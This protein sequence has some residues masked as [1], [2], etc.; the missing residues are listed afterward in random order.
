MVDCSKFAKRRDSSLF[1]GA[2]VFLLLLAVLACSS[3]AR[4]C[5]TTLTY[6]GRTYEGADANQDKATHNACNKYCRSDDP[7]YDAMYRI[8]LDSPPGR[9]AGRPSKEEAIFKDKRLLDYVT[10]TCAEKC[11][12]W[13][14]EGKAKAETKCD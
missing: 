10:I 8:W 13:T 4:K 6:Q 12:V 3:S 14:R 5:T 1:T 7:E 11:V 2:A 9:A